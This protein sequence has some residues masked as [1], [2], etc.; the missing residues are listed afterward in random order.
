M[1]TPREEVNDDWIVIEAHPEAPPGY[2]A[3]FL[4]GKR[5][6]R[7]PVASKFAP[8]GSSVVLESLGKLSFVEGR[9]CEVFGF[10]PKRSDE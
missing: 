5:F 3:P 1:G 7:P 2:T 10:R 4:L 9:V 6:L 8:P